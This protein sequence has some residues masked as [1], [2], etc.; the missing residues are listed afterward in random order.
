VEVSVLQWNIWFKEPIEHVAKFLKAHP[1][2]IICL[3]ELTHG[4]DQQ[5]HPDTAKYIADE[6]GFH[7]HTKEIHIPQE[8]WLQANGIFTRFPI[9]ATRDAWINDFHGDDSDDQHRSYIEATLQVGGHELLVGTTHL[10]LADGLADTV[11]KRQETDRLCQAL[12]RGAKYQILTGDFNAPPDSYTVSAVS[13]KLKQV[14]PDLDQKTWATKPFL[15]DDGFEVKDLSLRVDYVFASPNIE[16][17]DTEILTT[18][19]SDH[20]PVL[21]KIR[22]P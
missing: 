8:T 15:G 2:D 7:Y 6:L 14:G 4:L 20:L 10:S 13:S 5:S 12:P 19:A 1:A 3:Q 11:R 22:L 18:D 21:A 9:I 17:I 16:V